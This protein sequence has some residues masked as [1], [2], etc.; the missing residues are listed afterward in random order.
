[1]SLLSLPSVTTLYPITRPGTVLVL[2][3]LLSGSWKRKGKPT[4]WWSG[5]RESPGVGERS[6]RR[7]PTR[8]SRLVRTKREVVALR[9]QDTGRGTS[10][11]RDEMRKFVKECDKRDG[12]KGRKRNEGS[13]RLIGL[14][15]TRR[16]QLRTRRRYGG[17][18]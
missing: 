13:E 8:D 15:K 5:R 3:E 18:R 9:G 16:S 17:I 4:G 7:C 11:M 1:M 14:K 10:E 6:E 12:P 2:Q